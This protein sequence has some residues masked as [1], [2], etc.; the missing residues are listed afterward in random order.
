MK[1][2]AALD[3]HGRA[4]WVSGSELALQGCNPPSLPIFGAVASISAVVHRRRTGLRAN[5]ESLS[6]SYPISFWYLLATSKSSLW[7]SAGYHE[8]NLLLSDSFLLG[9]RYSIAIFRG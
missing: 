2:E 9:F 3:A 5:H 1:P 7:V 4:S 8:N 6:S